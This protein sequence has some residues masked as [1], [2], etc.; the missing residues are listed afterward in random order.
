MPW[1]CQCHHCAP[2]RVTAQTKYSDKSRFAE[3]DSCEVIQGEALELAE[4]QCLAHFSK[5]GFTE[6]RATEIFKFV[7]RGDNLSVAASFFLY[8]NEGAIPDA[9]PSGLKSLGL[10]SGVKYV[11]NRDVARGLLIYRKHPT[12]K[13]VQVIFG[14]DGKII[15]EQSPD[16]PLVFNA[17]RHE[18]NPDSVPL[19]LAQARRAA[20]KGRCV[21]L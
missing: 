16:N 11:V 21:I 17:T 13:E 15:F 4:G 10:G 14:C 19:T 9:T 3:T 8:D 20:K 6:L 18:V 1:Y 12:S 2:I 5:G 7:S